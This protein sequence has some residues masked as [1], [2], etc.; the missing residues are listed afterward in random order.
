MTQSQSSATK[1]HWPAEWVLHEATWMGFPCRREIWTNGLEKAQRAFAEVANQISEYEPVKMI[2]PAE[3]QKM[4]KKLL[5][6]GVEQLTADIDDSWARDTSPVWVRQEQSMYG[7]DFEFNCWGNK[8]KPFDNDRA[9][10]AKICQ[11]S[12]TSR[13]EN[14]LILEGGSVHSN[15]RGVLLTT[16][17]CLL[18]PNRNPHLSQQ[19]IEQELIK[20]LG[21]EQFI[22]LEKGVAGDVDTDGHIDN[23]ACFVNEKTILTQKCS[24]DSENFSI[25]RDNKNIIQAAKFDL[26]EIAEPEARYHQG[27]REPLSYINFYIANGSVIIP[28]F[29]CKQD[30]EAYNVISE[31]F[32][33]RKVHAIDANEI[34][35]GGGGIH[36]ITMQQPKS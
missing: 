10:A 22:W 33:D 29:G 8:F 20:A 24:Q 18:N 13:I 21:V 32:A 26:L 36:C 12:Q 34:L 30:D 14:S 5:S 6:A 19:A 4:A 35:V 2:V 16:K 23:I 7:V 15:D 3:H 31:I 17:E 28:K 25:Y 9:I 11:F 27:M 1:V